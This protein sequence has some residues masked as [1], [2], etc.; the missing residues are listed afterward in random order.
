MSDHLP[1]TRPTTTLVVPEPVVAMIAELGPDG[2]QTFATFFADTIRNPNTR[3]AYMRAFLRF[4][5]WLED[6]HLTLPTCAPFDAGRYVE[7]LTVELAPATVKQH[8]AALRRAC[9]YLTNKGVLSKNPFTET[10]GPN[11][12][13]RVGKTPALSR[14]DARALFDGIDPG[15][16]A[17]LRD[18]AL[19]GLMIYSFARIGAALAMNVGDYFQNGRRMIVQLH[20]KGGKEHQM[21]AH[22][23][24]VEYLD[25]YLKALAP[26][27]LEGPL[28]R[29][30]RRDRRGFTENRLSR[31]EAWAMV[32]RRTKQFGPKFSN[33]T[34]RAT[35]IT[36]YLANDGQLDKAQQMAAHA[37]TQTTK[38]YD[39]RN[40]EA[41]LDE[42][43][44][45]IL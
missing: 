43:E 24:L 17:G 13:V 19:L 25:A 9:G 36:T 1:A 28:F 45:I 11:H 30:V 5:R 31:Y 21:P 12:T 27:D 35:G 40:E 34:F 18:R 33:H 10:K 2:A 29:T 37:S 32:K 44:R 42:V 39:R 14:E 8:L 41:S 4:A 6:Q 23:T 38:L 22:H 7:L 26:E 3:A 16:P 15:T 20:E